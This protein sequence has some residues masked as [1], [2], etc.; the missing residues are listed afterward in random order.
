MVALTTAV[1]AVGDGDGVHGVAAL[2]VDAQPLVGEWLR[3]RAAVVAQVAVPVAVHSVAG[4]MIAVVVIEVSALLSGLAHGH[5]GQF[6]SV[7]WS[8]IE[9]G[10]CLLWLPK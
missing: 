5:V 2:E 8:F 6:D 9:I 1:A 7:A 4:Q 3:V 10:T